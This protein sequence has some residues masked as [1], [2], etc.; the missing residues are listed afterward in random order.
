MPLDDSIRDKIELLAKDNKYTLSRYLGNLDFPPG[1]IQAVDWNGQSNAENESSTE[2]EGTTD[3]DET[4]EQNTLWKLEATGEFL[5]AGSPFLRFKRNFR[6]L[7]QSISAA[8]G[9]EH[10]CA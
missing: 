2:G 5:T 3:E 1:P 7:I 8:S 10:S 9:I 4:E 6:E